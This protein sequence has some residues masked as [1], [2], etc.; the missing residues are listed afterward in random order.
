[1][2]HPIPS[3]DHE[4]H[5]PLVVGT[6]KR[7]VPS[8]RKPMQMRTLLESARH[9]RV[10]IAAF[11]V[12]TLEHAEAI[13]SGA[14]R[15]GRPVILQLSQNCIRYHG[16]LEP[17]V[18]ALFAVAAASSVPVCVHLDHLDD[19]EL[20][21]QG[22]ELGVDGI[23]IDGSQLPGDRNLELTQAT[24]ARAHA[25]GVTVEAELGEVGGKDGDHRAADR[26]EPASAAA[27]AVATEVDALAVAVGTSHAMT[28]RVAHVDLEL[29]AALRASVVTPLVLHGASGLSDEQLRAAVRAGMTKV[30]VA[31]HLNVLFTAAIRDALRKSPDMVDPRRYLAAGRD[32][33]GDE[34]A[35]LLDLIAGG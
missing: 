2:S 21:T 18:S 7:A 3:A 29:I 34:C 27:F 12:V 25:A 26:T 4:P 11:N 30:N 5:E 14:E 9:D 1:M 35:R 20:V 8:E 15:A 23:M 33:I 16:A 19:P 22:I 6:A 32:A 17:I 31:T 28:Q 13:V 10:G 24:V